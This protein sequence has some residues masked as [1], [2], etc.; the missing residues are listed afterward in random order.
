MIGKFIRSSRHVQEN[1]E[2]LSEIFILKFLWKLQPV[3]MSIG[4]S[5][6]S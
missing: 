6:F 4:V 5:S 1:K 3:A 2:L